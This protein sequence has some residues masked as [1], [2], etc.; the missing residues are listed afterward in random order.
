VPIYSYQV[1][2]PDG[3]KIRGSMEAVSE[4]TVINTLTNKGFVIL[5]IKEVKRRGF[6]P[7][8]AVKLEDIVTFS[9][10]LSVMISAGVRIRNAL[11]ILSKQESFSKRFRRVLS[12][13]IVSLETGLSL[14]EA[15]RNEKV[16]DEIFIN[17]VESG[18]KGGVLD[19]ALERIA[20]FYED[21]KR[22]RDEVKSAMTYPIFVLIFAIIIVFVISFF[23]LPRLISAFGTL[24]T[25]PVINT[26]IKVN[27][28]LSDNWSWVL[29]AGISIA[30][31]L[32]V[33]FKTKIGVRVKSIMANVIPIV[34]SIRYGLAVERFT[35]TLG[36]LLESGVAITDAIELAAR[37]SENHRIEDAA[38][39]M[40]DM[41]KK[42]VSLKEALLTVGVLPK[43]VAEM[44]GTGEET[45]KLPE[46]L[47]KVSEFYDEEVR[48]K[49]KKLVSMVEPMMI[50]LVGG[51]IAFLALTMYQTIFTMQQSI[52]R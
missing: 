37:S 6:G 17:L 51:F 18:E 50:A 38:P 48:N 13:I 14:A 33:F 4:M 45:G 15:M 21:M 1:M 26:L 35:R 22:L 44:V 7:I 8:F 29:V 42:G 43:I 11:E 27:R 36:V 3:K 49:V 47:E 20:T 39:E 10:Q 52:G 40:V 5:D 28:F 9:R 34:R 31:G 19:I 24:P 2:S 23:I 32:Y 16:F 41:V 12:N 30:V 46:I 25:N